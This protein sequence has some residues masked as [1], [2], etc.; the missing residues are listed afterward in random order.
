M[1]FYVVKTKLPIYKIQHFEHEEHEPDF[2]AND[3]V[4]HI[5][6]HHF[7]TTPHKHDFYLTVLFTKGSG[8]HEIDFNTYAIKPGSVFMM[9]PGQ[10]HNWKFSKGTDGYVFFHTKDF[11]NSGF[12]KANVDIY[13]FFQ[14]LQNPPVINLDKADTEKLGT[15]FK[16]LVSEHEQQAYLKFEKIHA[17]VNLIY[18]ELSRHYFPTVQLSNESY[19]PKVR[20]LENLIDQYFKTKKYPYE[21]ADMMNLSEKHLNRMSKACLNKTTT[22]L[23]ADRIV[24]EAKRLL[25]HSKQN[26]SE[27]A[28]ELGYE[29]NSYFSR[30]FK[31]NTGYAPLQFLKRA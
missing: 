10:M 12:T 23:I 15:L 29:N 3:F 1:Y 5:T 4:S 26:I 2:Y 28:A 17:L 31:K 9:S 13:P 19:L 22:E 11:Y 20:V 21:Y 24:L 18:V 8:T 25:I 30:F 27:I 7:A 14:S 6:H 16:E